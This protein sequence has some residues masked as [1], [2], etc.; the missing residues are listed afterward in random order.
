MVLGGLYDPDVLSSEGVRSVVLEVV[1]RF[2][3]IVGSGLD[4][5]LAASDGV[6][7]LQTDVQVAFGLKHAS[8]AR[9]TVHEIVLTHAIAA[10]RCSAGSLSRFGELLTQEFAERAAGYP[11]GERAGATWDIVGVPS[12]AARVEDVDRAVASADVDPQTRSMLSQ[13]LALAGFAGRIVVEKTRS[14]PSVELVRGYTF[15]LVGLLPIDASFVGP[16]VACIDGHVEDVSEI[17]HLL[18]ESAEAKEPVVLFVR[19][20]ADE[21]KHTLRV[22]YD[23]GSLR[24]V[25]VGVPFDLEG[26]N[27]LVDLATV[28]GTDVVS[29]LKGDL[30]SS[31]RLS[32]MPRVDAVLLHGN[33][34]VV[35][36][37][38]SHK[39]VAQH[40][41][42]LRRKRTEENIDDVGRL[43]D[44]RIRSLSPN[45]V[46]IRLVDDRSFVVRSQAID[47][48]LRTV[49]SLVDH[50]VVGEDRRLAATE[51]AARLYSGR[52]AEQLR[53]LG[54]FIGR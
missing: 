41:E 24:V 53:S 26:M 37:T 43:L 40:V 32:G 18:E 13:A 28:A 8:A 22:N 38:A 23:R 51:V 48:A 21:V 20:M 27:T 39:S 12:L 19:G 2:T 25:P 52:C 16:R 47:R 29:S 17:H 4:R 35:A 1:D 6:L 7:S 3:G 30:I 9:R 46:V 50:G 31:V 33:R 49:R 5:S 42:R 54:A 15:D 34:V 14:R 45:H 36:S 10:E 11:S 44:K